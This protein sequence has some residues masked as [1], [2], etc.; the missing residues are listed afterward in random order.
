[1]YFSSVGFLYEA[2][3]WLN[4]FGDCFDVIR[5]CSSGNPLDAFTA[6]ANYF[7]CTYCNIFRNKNFIVLNVI[8]LL[9]VLFHVVLVMTMG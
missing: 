2:G 7:R 1:M 3:N 9:R 5:Y 8:Q 6:I 4:W